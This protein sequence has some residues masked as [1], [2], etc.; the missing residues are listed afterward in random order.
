MPTRVVLVAGWMISCFDQRTSTYL[1]ATEGH[2]VT[3]SKK[4]AAYHSTV[5]HVDAQVLELAQVVE[6]SPS[7]SQQCQSTIQSRLEPM[8]V[9]HATDHASTDDN[10]PTPPS[11]PGLE[12]SSMHSSPP[13]SQVDCA[14]R[15]MRTPD[16][17]L[18]I[19]WCLAQARQGSP[20]AMLQASDPKTSLCVSKYAVMLFA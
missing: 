1:E 13:S 2:Q 15:G 19:L 17:L 6:R 5:P 11:M 8:I 3:Y 4:M 20:V 12:S 14:C 10:A 9:R 18:L 7:A 16:S